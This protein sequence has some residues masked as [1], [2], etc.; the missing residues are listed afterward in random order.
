MFGLKSGQK[1]TK[2]QSKHKI[3]AR[4]GLSMLKNPYNNILFDHI[5]GFELVLIFW[6]QI[7]SYLLLLQE[8]T[9]AKFP[10]LGSSH[11]RL[12]LNETIFIEFWGLNRLGY[13][14]AS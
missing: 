2:E 5:D 14:L 8:G 1:S 9:T 3:E 4:F 11:S 6:V 10:T 13:I 7:L 12:W